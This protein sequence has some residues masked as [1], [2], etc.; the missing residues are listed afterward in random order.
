MAIYAENTS[1]PSTPAPEGNHIAR[2]VSMIDMG[3]Q[4]NKFDP[5]KADQRKVQLGFELPGEL[6]EDGKPFLLRQKFTLTMHEKGS[7]RKFLQA[8]RG[9]AFTEEEAKRFDITKLLG[10]ACMLNVMHETKEGK[11]YANISTVAQMPKGMEAPAQL[12]PTLE[13]SLDLASYDALVY[14]SLPDYL[15][16]EIALSPEYRA[17]QAPAAKLEPVTA[18]EEEGLPF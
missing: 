3:T 11:T 18:D 2:C 17:L 7:L 10:L 12:T 9:K 6:R 5:S 15:K 13:F 1:A 4:K 14:E 8:W 16:E